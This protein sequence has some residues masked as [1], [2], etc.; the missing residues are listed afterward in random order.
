MGSKEVGFARA[1]NF[2]H[3][4]EQ[5]TALGLEKTPPGHGRV[6]N[7]VVTPV[8]TSEGMQA[9]DQRE[10]GY[11][12]I[13]VTPG[14]LQPLGWPTLPTDARVWMYVPVGHDIDQTPGV[15]LNPAS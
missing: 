3:P 7:G 13:A 15:A 12:R 8:V 1:W 14:Q 5:I 9:V 4:T 11:K 10:V 2:Q 6:I